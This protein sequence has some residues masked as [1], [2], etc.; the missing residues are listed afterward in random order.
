LS[1]GEKQ[2]VAFARA[3]AYDPGILILDEA[4]ASV[5]HETEGRIQ[6]ALAEVFSGRTNIVIA[7]RL[8]TVRSAD[9]IIV[10][11]KGQLREIGTH[12]ELLA[13][14]GIYAR[15]HRLQ[16]EADA[17]STVPSPRVKVETA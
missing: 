15:L 5:D 14:D 17:P 2:L 7:H 11:H 6:T 1:V 9:R 16:F 8:S 4:T 13:L 12:I 10:L 3:I